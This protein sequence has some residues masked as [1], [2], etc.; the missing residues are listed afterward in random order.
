[1]EAPL[2]LILMLKEH[3]K[4]TVQSTAHREA[5]GGRKRIFLSLSCDGF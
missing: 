1:M 4:R 3:I 5:F 2:T